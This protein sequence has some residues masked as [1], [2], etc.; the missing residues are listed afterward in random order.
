[1]PQGAIPVV[2]QNSAA[3]GLS[4]FCNENDGSDATGNGSAQRPFAS[5][6][7][8]F[9]MARANKG[10]VVYLQRTSHRTA[11]LTWDKDGVSLVALSA[12]SDNDRGRI[13]PLGGAAVF[14]PLVHV[15]AQG[16]SF[17]NVGTFHGF[18]DNSAQICWE[19]YGG[20]NFYSNCQ[21][22]GMGATLAAGHTGSR[23]LTIAG[24]GENLFV[25][26]TFGIDTIARG[27]ANATL[28]LLAG[29]PRNIMRDC[30]FQMLATAA[31]PM[32]ITVGSGGMDR[33]LLL[34]RP[35]F[36]N[37]VDSTGTAID[38]AIVANASAGGT[39]AV[40]DGF[41]IGAT[42]IATTGPVRGTGNVPTAA[43]SGIA[44]PLT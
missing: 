16:C 41:S 42:A 25:G 33:Y 29:T 40:K 27:V 1:M 31:T 4:I 24:A 10:D 43:T 28:E 8:G 5:L 19:E 39:V 2:V 26:C 30:I 20:R 32:H 38:A 18:A 15:T 35:A 44:I 11:T 17:V 9:D 7:A 22:L 36:I 34:D 12:P 37:C 13:S 6:D 23:S 3:A 14:S 21:L